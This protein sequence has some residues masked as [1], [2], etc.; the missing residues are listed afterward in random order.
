MIQSDKPLESG[1][2]DAAVLFSM[3]G[4]CQKERRRGDGLHMSTG[5]FGSGRSPE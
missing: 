5:L 3:C 1:S 4:P 2:R